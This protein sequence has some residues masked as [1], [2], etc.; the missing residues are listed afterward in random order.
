MDKKGDGVYVSGEE[1][2]EYFGVFLVRFRFVQPRY[3][4]EPFSEDIQG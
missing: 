2:F 1:E 3:S 4:L